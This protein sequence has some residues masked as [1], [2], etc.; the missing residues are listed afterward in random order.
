M[1]AKSPS[2][3]VAQKIRAARRAEN[4]TQEEFARL[5]NVSTRTVSRWELGDDQPRP[6]RLRQ[7]AKLTGR[8]VSW[9][10]DSEDELI[11]ALINAL[12]VIRERQADREE[13]AA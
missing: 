10:L 1:S 11:D 6:K 4:W 8:R 5:L 13:E 9:L 2:M 7:I 3:S 12:V